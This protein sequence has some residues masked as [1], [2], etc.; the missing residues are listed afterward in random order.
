[1]YLIHGVKINQLFKVLVSTLGYRSLVHVNTKCHTQTIFDV[2]VRILNLIGYVL[3]SY[4][5]LIVKFTEENLKVKVNQLFQ[6]Q[7]LFLAMLNKFQ[8]PLGNM[9]VSHNVGKPF[10]SLLKSQIQSRSFLHHFG[11]W[12]GLFILKHYLLN[13]IELF[14][15]SI[16]ECLN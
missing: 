10:L 2:D 7:T 11:C 1:M 9:H 8:E 4:L 3:V 15:K 14:V 12:F 13:F 5:K 6:S 16:Q